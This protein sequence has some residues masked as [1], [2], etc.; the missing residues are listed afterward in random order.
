MD[1][2]SVM[3]QDLAALSV[4]RTAQPPAPPR[5]TAETVPHAAQSASP[6]GTQTNQMSAGRAAVQQQLPEEK[7]KQETP[8]NRRQ[9]QGQVL[10]AASDTRNDAL[11]ASAGP[12][13]RV[14]PASKKIV[15]QF[16]DE[17][18]EVVRQV[19]PEALM[20]LASAFDNVEGMFLDERM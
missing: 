18:G 13:L 19:P 3:G 10:P 1:V 11:P 7:A 16:V 4:R 17:H 15:A 2:T 12:R 6:S 8:L 20:E 14:D 5:R 9:D